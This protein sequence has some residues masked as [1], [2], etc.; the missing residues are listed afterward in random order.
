MKKFNQIEHFGNT[1]QIIGDI[2]VHFNF[3][4][5]KITSKN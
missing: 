3:N 4:F 2:W 5:D 1:W